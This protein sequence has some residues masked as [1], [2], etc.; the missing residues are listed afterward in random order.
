MYFDQK[1][2]RNIR[3]EGLVLKSMPHKHKRDKSNDATAYVVHS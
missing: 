1:L 3:Y 2:C